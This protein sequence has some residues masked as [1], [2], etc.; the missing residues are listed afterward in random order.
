MFYGP[1]GDKGRQD[2]TIEDMQ[3]VVFKALLHFVY[4][5]SV[6]PMKDLDDGE[7][8]EMVKHLL[9]AA[10]R[11]G[12]KRMKMMCESILCKSLDVETVTT[13]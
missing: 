9:V 10:H 3:P 6:P 8:R 13:M 7:K 12:M 1:M 4:T 5:D 2:I 11:Y